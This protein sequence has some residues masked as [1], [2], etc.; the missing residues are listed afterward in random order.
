MTSLLSP[1]LAF[2]GVA[3]LVLVAVIAVAVVL[4]RRTNRR[5]GYRSPH[6]RDLEARRIRAMREANG[7]DNGIHE[8][9]KDGGFTR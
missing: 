5:Q 2:Y 8:Y 3:V 6:D 4:G 9:A 7:M 1:L